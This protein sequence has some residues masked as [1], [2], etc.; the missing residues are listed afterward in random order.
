MTS[1]GFEK[2]T[3]VSHRA[4]KNLGKLVIRQTF[5]DYMAEVDE[6]LITR[7]EAIRLSREFALA[8]SDEES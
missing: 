8:L 7:E 5:D 2:S 6:R 4:V 3:W 1:H